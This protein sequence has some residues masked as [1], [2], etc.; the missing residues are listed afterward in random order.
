MLQGR[1]LLLVSEW[2]S[3]ALSW[4]YYHIN[5]GHLEAGLKKIR[6]RETF[7]N[8]NR[9]LRNEHQRKFGKN[10][11]EIY[12]PTAGNNNETDTT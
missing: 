5:Q 6:D 4:D 2:G 1:L 10:T 11:E 12:A 3:G 8:E 7:V 9:Q